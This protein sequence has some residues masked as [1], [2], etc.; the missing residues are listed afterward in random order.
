[1]LQE[2]LL[3]AVIF[4]LSLLD[5]VRRPILIIAATRAL[6]EWE[7][8]FSKWSRFTNVVTYKGSEY[9]RAAIRNLEFYDENESITFQ[10]LLSSPD[11]IVEV[12]YETNMW[13]T[14]LQ[15]VFLCNELIL[16]LLC[17]RI[18]ICLIILSGN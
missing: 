10:V 18:W 11:V 17:C 7:A 8:E 9:V 14:L 1:M 12:Q 13:I 2:R 3:K 15:L 5:N 16:M 4:V 6:S